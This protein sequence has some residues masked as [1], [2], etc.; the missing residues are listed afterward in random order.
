MNFS[1]RSLDFSLLPF[2]AFSFFFSC[3][4]GLLLHELFYPLLGLF[5]VAFLCLFL[6]LFLLL[7]F[8]RWLLA[9]LFVFEGLLELFPLSLGLL[10]PQSSLS[11]R[12]GYFLVHIDVLDTLLAVDNFS[13]IV[14]LGSKRKDAIGQELEPL[15]H[16]VQAFSLLVTN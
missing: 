14:Q 11:L 2:F 7:G 16:G 5:L 9:S 4:L 1:I 8:R 12:L 15:G 10:R 13:F 6:L 3:F